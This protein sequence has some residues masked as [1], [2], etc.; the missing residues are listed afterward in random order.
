MANELVYVNLNVVDGK[1]RTSTVSIPFRLDSLTNVV[2]LIALV[3]RVGS[4]VG[5]LSTAG[6]KSAEIC[7]GVDITTIS[8]DNVDGL[9]DE[10]ALGDVQEKALFAFRTQADALGKQHTFTRTIPAVN[11]EVV[12]LPSADAINTTNQDVIDFIEMFTNGLADLSAEGGA[13][14]DVVT[15]IDSRGLDLLAF[16]EGGQTWGNRRKK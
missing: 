6:L 9:N 13:A 16:V 3:R 10:F 4:I 11:D 7:L 1:N 15:A 12:F 2:S 14:G 8:W 5:K